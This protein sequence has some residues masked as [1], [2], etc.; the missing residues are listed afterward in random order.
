MAEVSAERLPIRSAIM[1]ACS[2]CESWTKLGVDQQATIARRVERGCFEVCVEECK[3]Q[4]V[5]RQFTDAKFINR[6]SAIASR[7]IANLDPGGSVYVINV[8]QETTLNDGNSLVSKLIDGEIDPHNVARMTSRELCPA[9]SDK[10]CKEIEMRKRQKIT[11][12][13]SR[14]YTCHKCKRNET[15]LKPCQMRSADEEENVLI[16]CVHCHFMWKI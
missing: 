8:L 9:A 4:G 10:I 16:T 3:A 6:Y 13:V 5:N 15:L 14:A 2:K 11:Q 12:K 7:V 1:N